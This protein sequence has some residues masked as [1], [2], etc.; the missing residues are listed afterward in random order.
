M[1]RWHPRYYSL[2]VLVYWHVDY[3]FVSIY[4]QLKSCAAS[5]LSLMIEGILRH[6]TDKVINKNYVDTHE[7]SEIGFVF[8]HLLS[9]ELLPRLKNINTQKLY[10]ADKVASSKYNN[11]RE[12]LAKLI[13]WKIIEQCYYEIIKYT[14]VLK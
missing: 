10:Y 6:N 7:V 4:F 9:F 5:E 1:S 13:D 11:L 12:I 8:F 14:V 3:N 2:G